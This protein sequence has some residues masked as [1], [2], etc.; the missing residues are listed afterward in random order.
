MTGLMFLQQKMSQIKMSQATEQQQLMNIMFP[1]MFGVIF[2]NMPS[3]LVL[4]WFI[5]S[6]L[7]VIYQWRLKSRR[8]S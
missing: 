3:G 4:Y 6:L 1:L 5:N 2:Y 8:L 7:M